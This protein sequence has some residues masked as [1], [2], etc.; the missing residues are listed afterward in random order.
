MKIKEIKS[1]IYSFI[2]MNV[3]IGINIL[4]YLSFKANHYSIDDELCLKADNR[5]RA[6]LKI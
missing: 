5:L 1:G 3:T 2:K 4:Q 6:I